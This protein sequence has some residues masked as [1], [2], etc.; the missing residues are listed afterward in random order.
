MTSRSNPHLWPP[1]T[2]ARTWSGRSVARRSACFTPKPTRCSSQYSTR[3]LSRMGTS[4]S[5]LGSANAATFGRSPGQMSTAFISTGPLSRQHRGHGLRQDFYIEPKALVFDVFHVEIHLAGEIDL[6]APANLP[7]TGEAR[8]D[9][10][11]AAIGQ[12]VALHLARHGRA[13]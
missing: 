10:Q 12:S 9:Q 1:P 7:E 2:N 5:G 13:R 4:A 8:F 11:A 3:H 6:A